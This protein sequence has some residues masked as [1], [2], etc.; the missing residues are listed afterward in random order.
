VTDESLPSAP[1]DRL[2]AG[3][4]KRVRSSSSTP[5]T[6]ATAPTNPATRAIGADE[7]C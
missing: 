4:A 6:E 3:T 2:A 1:A 7:R 5:V